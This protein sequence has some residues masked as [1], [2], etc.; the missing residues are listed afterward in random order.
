M[1]TIDSL[2][3]EDK[4]LIESVRMGTLSADEISVTGF[5]DLDKSKRIELESR[6]KK[7]RD[8]DL[9]DQMRETQEFIDRMDALLAETKARIELLRLKREEALLKSQE[10]FDRMHEAEDLM[11]SIED[12]ISFEERQ[13]VVTL[14]GAEAETMS[15][16]ELNALL[17]E[18]MQKSH[19]AGVEHSEEV[20]QLDEE[21]REKQERYDL[22][23][24][25]RDAYERTS[26]PE[27]RQQIE[28]TL[29]DLNDQPASKTTED[30]ESQLGRDQDFDFPEFG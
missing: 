24:A 30:F 10:A 11:L 6:E 3:P 16:T 29:H 13:R 23:K 25:K 27:A 1:A 20:G 15:A 14:L 12:G 28:Q 21:I 17:R 22:L 4:R 2:E 19:K 8:R 7:K 5:A 9:S 18:T 26:T